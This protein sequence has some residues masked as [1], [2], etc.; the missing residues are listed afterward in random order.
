MTASKH[1]LL[2]MWL[3]LACAL[4]AGAQVRF[5]PTIATQPASQTVAAGS[6]VTFSVT[7]NGTPPLSYQWRLNTANIGGANSSTYVIASA[8]ASNAGDYTVLVTNPA[9]EILS[10]PATLT[11]TAPPSI[12]V[13]PSSQTAFAGT[14]VTLSV[15]ATGTAPLSY[16]WQFNGVDVAGAKSST[17]GFTLKTAK[18]GAYRVVVSNPFGSKTSSFAVLDVIRGGAVDT[19]LNPGAG[20]NNAVYAVALQSDGKLLLGGAFT[21][22]D[23]VARNRIV[24]LNS[25]GSLDTSFAPGSGVNAEVYAIAVQNDGKIIIG[26]T[27]DSFNGFARNRIAR[28]NANG[29]LDVTFNPGLG[30]DER[31]RALALQGDG[32][33][34]IGGWFKLYNG[35]ARSGVARI[36]ANGTLDTTFNPGSGTDRSVYVVVLQNDGRIMIGGDFFSYDGVPRNAIARLSANGSVDTSF[37]PG[38]GVKDYVYTIGLQSDNKI[39]I[40]GDFNAYDGTARNSIARLNADGGLD[41]SF[42]PGSGAGGHVYAIAQQT[43]GRIDIAGSFNA[44]HGVP[45]NRIARIDP[46]GNLDRTFNPGAGVDTQVYAFALQSD[47]NMVLGGDFTSYNQVARSGVA[48]VF[49]NETPTGQGFPIVTA[50]SSSSQNISNF[51]E[52]T[53][54]GQPVYSS[55][56]T[57]SLRSYVLTAGDDGTLTIDTIGSGFDTSLSVYTGTSLLDLTLVA[58]NDNGAPDGVRSLVRFAAVKGTSYLIVVAG[59]NGVQG[60]TIVNW[61]LTVQVPLKVS[62]SSPAANSTFKTTDNVTITAEASDSDGEITSVAF[63]DGVTLLGAVTASPYSIAK[64]FGAGSH[65]ITAVAIDNQGVHVTSAPLA[66][67]VVANVAPAVAI[68]S[69]SDGSTFNV[70]DT[71]TI[72]VSALDPDGTVAQV[73]FFDGATLLSIRTSPPYKILAVLIPGAHTLTAKATDDNAAVTTSTP[74]NLTVGANHPPAVSLISPGDASTFTTGDVVTL[75]AAASDSDGTIAKVEFFD[76]ANLLGTSTTPPYMTVAS[77]SAGSHSITVKATDDFGARTTSAAVVIAVTPGPQ[78]LVNGEI[79]KYIYLASSTAAVEASIQSPFAGGTTFYTTDGSDPAGGQEYSQPFAVSPPFSI[80][81][82]AFNSDFTKFIELKP[83]NSLLVTTSGGGAISTTVGRDQSGVA[84]ADLVATP[85]AGWDFVGWGQDAVGTSSTL[86][87]TMERGKA[88]EALFGTQ[89]TTSLVGTGTILI[90]PPSALH[91]YGSVV[92]ISAIPST[93]NYFRFW[94]G[95]LSRSIQSPV[96]LKITTAKPSISALFAATPA[97]PPT[98]FAL[99]VLI[100]GEG[101]VTRSPYFGYYTNGNNVTLKATAAAGSQFGGW[102]IHSGVNETTSLDNPLVV[103]IDAQKTVTATFLKINPSPQVGQSLWELPTGLQRLSQT[104]AIAN[105]GTVYIGASSGDASQGRLIAM[106]P[107]GQIKW[108]AT[109]PGF[110]YQAYPVIGPNGDIYYRD[111]DLYGGKLHALN[112]QNGQQRWVTDV[113]IGTPAIGND[114]T[115]YAGGDHVLYSINPQNGQTNW[116]HQLDALARSAPAIG[117]DGT[118]YIASITDHLYA[119]TPDNQSRGDANGFVFFTDGSSATPPIIGWDG[120][121]YIANSSMYALTPDLKLLWSREGGDPLI[122]TTPVITADG[123]I[124]ENVYFYDPA[125]QFR[126][127]R[128]DDGARSNLFY[129]VLGRGPLGAPAFAAN[130]MMYHAGV[131][132]ASGSPLDPREAV[133]GRLYA[134]KKDGTLDWSF[135]TGQ[136]G[137]PNYPTIPIIGVDGTIYFPSG[138]TLF[139]IKAQAAPANSAWGMFG[140]D[141]KHDGNAS[142]FDGDKLWQFDTGHPN[143]SSI[144]PALDSQGTVYFAGGKTLFA[145]SNGAVKWQFDVRAP[146]S[147]ISL[148]VIA[149]DDTIY[150]GDDTGMLYALTRDGKTKWEPIQANYFFYAPPALGAD[151]T[152]YFATWH[153]TLEALDPITHQVRSLFHADGTGDFDQITSITIGADGTIYCGTR[154]THKFYALSRGGDLRSIDLNEHVATIPAV[155]RD[156]TI[157]LGTYDLDAQGIYALNPDLSVKW[158][159]LT[160]ALTG[161]PGGI[162]EEGTIYL[163]SGNLLGYNWDGTPKSLWQPG[164]DL[165]FIRSSPA[166]AA[167]HT[168]YFGSDNGNLYALL[169]NGTQKWSYWTGAIQTEPLHPVIASDG[170]IYFPVG[171]QLYA[172]KGSNTPG[173]GPWPM[174][175]KN[176]RHTANAGSLAGEVVLDLSLGSPVRSAPAMTGRG[177]LI[178]GAGDQLYSLDQQGRTN[179]VKSVAGQIYSANPVISPNGNIFLIAYAGGGVSLL[180]FDPNGNTLWNPPVPYSTTAGFWDNPPALSGDGNIYVGSNDGNLYALDSSNGN[181]RWKLELGQPV[182]NQGGGVSAVAIGAAGTYLCVHKI[183]ASGETNYLYAIDPPGAATEA[184][185]LWRQ[186][187]AGL[188]NNPIV[189]MGEKIYVTAGSTLYAFNGIDGA[190]LWPARPLSPDYQGV[191]TTAAA[192]G[193][194]GTVYVV[195]GQNNFYGARLHAIDPG[196]GHEKWHTA[197]D[198]CF[199]PGYQTPPLVGS[200]SVIYFSSGNAIFAVKDIGS[201]GVIQW[202]SPQGP[203]HPAGYYPGPYYTTPL[204]SPYGLLYCGTE[205]GHFLSFQASAQLALSAWPM[206][207]KNP[208]RNANAGGVAGNLLWSVGTGFHVRSSAAIDP[209]TGTVWSYI[210]GHLAAIAEN[211]TTSLK[212]DVLASYGSPA[213]DSEGF[214]YT[215][216]F[217]D[218]NTSHLFVFDSK[219][220][221]L[222]S[223]VPLEGASP[224]LASLAIGPNRVLYIGV[225]VGE[226]DSKSGRLYITNQTTGIFKSV[227]FPRPIT[228]A[229]AL[230]ANGGVILAAGEFLYSCDADGNILSTF[231]TDAT[232]PGDTA[233]VTGGPV[234]ASDG[235]VYICDQPGRLYAVKP[236]GKKLWPTRDLG[237]RI[238]SSPVVGSDGTLYVVAQDESVLLYALDGTNGRTKWSLPMPG[239]YSYSTP[240]LGSDNMIYFGVDNVLY[241][242]RFTDS[243]GQIEWQLPLGDAIFSSPTL[244]GSGR[245]FVGSDFGLFSARVSSLDLAGFWPSFL[246]DSGHSSSAASGL[247]APQFVSVAIT[248]AGLKLGLTGAPGSNVVIERSTN[249]ATWKRISTLTLSAGKADFTDADSGKF[250]AAFY[251]IVQP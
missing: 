7:A 83:V 224:G 94:G 78:V 169:E 193:G 101:T 89:I 162:Q 70:G 92:R 95:A 213:V 227:S 156:G 183:E 166:V 171:S 54:E 226:G 66:I 109:L 219:Q 238:D 96:E 205:A 68:T 80:R 198:R 108:A 172:M 127:F 186:G 194:D 116:T 159:D 155:G 30:P 22:Y 184:R 148:P 53:A 21:S 246:H 6:K 48:R 237:Y 44:Y 168:V 77:F 154:T 173:K 215:L 250:K 204:L 5:P 190:P 129:P 231:Q 75:T 59:L 13:Q 41:A 90:D 131:W 57:G 37:N 74:I 163:P 121:V 208:N 69:P 158:N 20:V 64:S 51:S 212:A 130:G 234:V 242:V 214:V 138:A 60:N 26:G 49:A 239:H 128:A 180:G 120:T 228:K 249:L 170:T 229:P 34:V 149:P 133:E 24:R 220:D 223:H 112:S 196:D 104:P 16:Q 192:L 107:S 230:D 33:I 203:P 31:V 136:P 111:G 152:I 36:N 124:V 3:L 91:A 161:P 4:P 110:L 140:K 99:T 176:A 87:L 71:I 79:V 32:K 222:V 125:D 14:P 189:G 167:D 221:R 118:I 39:L 225:A 35:V 134:C 164:S 143:S 86:H 97:A 157:Y 197:D 23:G 47:G 153:N 177:D 200:D 144:S 17:Y 84:Y 122:G 248:E 38:S 73:E 145:L 243:G 174:F 211:G 8:Q 245:L 81:V 210:N 29:T 123:S 55:N 40:G 65:S 209:T 62:L 93:G 18:I 52:T 244:T 206:P 187:L 12:T 217:D 2:M 218:Q 147:D 102:Q 28:I 114:G 137:D 56:P 19:S 42:D 100:A 146:A 61:S 139:A 25:D 235:S 185:V 115:I 11:V 216:S 50:G 46:A 191:S 202:T 58:Q 199:Y 105:D 45:R 9:G 195:S 151:G 141:P 63:Y 43:D 117:P 132:H 175:Q 240:A 88:A 27:F 241:G 15:S 76:G 247:V 178:F 188:G 179:W 201:S 10:Q 236:D 160:R 119:V 106:L 85:D 150:V 135:P 181:T 103:L 232:S 142:G 207:Q 72:T 82:A 1:H 233:Y 67:T 126:R 182:P 98:T 113:G 165:G 251:R